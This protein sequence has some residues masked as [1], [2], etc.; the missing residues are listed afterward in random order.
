MRPLQISVD[1]ETA[2]FEAKKY[3]AITKTRNEE[4]TKLSFDALLKSRHS[5]ENQSP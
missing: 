2:L 5:G 4:S 3:K 1:F